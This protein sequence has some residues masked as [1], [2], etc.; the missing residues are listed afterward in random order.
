MIPVEKFDDRNWLWSKLQGNIF[1]KRSLTCSPLSDETLQSYILEREVFCCVTCD[2]K[3]KNNR[4]FDAEMYCLEFDKG[5]SEEFVLTSV[6]SQ[7]LSL[8]HI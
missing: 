3:T 4:R 7:E 8:I 6:S 5:N 1:E 2:D